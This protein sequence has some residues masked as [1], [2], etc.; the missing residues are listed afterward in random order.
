MLQKICFPR[1]HT[2]RL[3]VASTT[4]NIA[5][6]LT[7]VCVL[8]GGDKYGGY[9]GTLCPPDKPVQL[10]QNDTASSAMNVKNTR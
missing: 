9:G 5:I 3:L 10:W 4:I 8:G 6:L 1:V 2:L 7:R